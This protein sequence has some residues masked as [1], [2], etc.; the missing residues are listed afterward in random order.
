MEGTAW[1]VFE[2]YSMQGFQRESEII[3]EEEMLKR[4]QVSCHMERPAVFS[5][6]PVPVLDP[7]KDPTPKAL[8]SVAMSHSVSVTNWH[9]PEFTLELVACL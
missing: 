5:K 8:L 6:A 7:H 1:E 3:N 9:F 4:A 2:A